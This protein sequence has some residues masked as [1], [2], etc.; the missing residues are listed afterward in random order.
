MFY[1][2]I[3]LYMPQVNEDVVVPD[4]DAF[5]IIRTK[6]DGTEER[7]QM[8][9]GPDGF[10]IGTFGDRVVVLDAPNLM[11]L[12]RQVQNV[13]VKKRPAKNANI[14]KKPASADVSGPEENKEDDLDSALWEKPKQAHDNT[15]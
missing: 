11:L 9:K 6:S 4:W 13:E 3:S 1:T 5:E 15:I 10:I 14:M 2:L 12:P 8:Q 7:S